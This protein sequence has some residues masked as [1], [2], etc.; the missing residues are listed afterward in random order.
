V[1]ETIFALPGLGQ[2]TVQS[3]LASDLVMVQGVVV[4]VAVTYV[5][6][7][8]LVDTSYAF[9]DPRVRKTSAA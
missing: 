7:N 6:L 2:L 9:L 5:L 8:S 3:V 1:V 4:F